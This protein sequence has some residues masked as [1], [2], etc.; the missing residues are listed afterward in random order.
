MREVR[1][2]DIAQL[3]IE[4]V[5]VSIDEEYRAA[6]VLNGGKGV[7]DRGTL[8][9]SETNYPALHRLRSGLLV[10]RKLTAWEGTVT[11]V[12]DA[13][14]GFVVSTEFP[15]FALDTEQILPPFMT[16]LCQRPEFWEALRVRSTGTVQRRK[17]VSPGQLLDVPVPLPPL[18]EQRRIVDLV[19]TVD[20]VVAAT[21]STIERLR[22]AHTALVSEC[23][24]ADGPP[25][26]LGDLVKMSSGPSWKALQEG[27]RPDRGTIPVLKI[28]NTR[29]DGH[30]VVGDPA[31]VSGL[32]TKTL[33]LDSSCL[34]VIRTNGNRARIGNVYRV[35]VE[36]EGHAVSAFQ[37]AMRPHDPSD[38][39]YLYCFLS[40]PSVQASI[41]EAASGTTGLGNIGI[42]WLKALV[43]P[44]AAPEIR[45]AIVGRAS[46]LS[47]AIDAAEHEHAALVDFRTALLADLLSGDHEI[48][49]SYD[50]LLESV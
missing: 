13:F 47:A 49:D 31:F 32:P 10:M 25:V 40:S 8:L 39:G 23:A 41:S 15:T 5:P 9:G 19:A 29:P 24:H 33:R 34:V 27:T 37:I 26:P 38:T 43:I 7:F 12:P 45:A 36:A 44:W 30:V 16:L 20:D 17:R 2:R 14:D 4:R 11:V 48:P 35:P 22:R 42:G 6:G 21:R 1:L 50:R 46:A 18:A 28:T 3:D